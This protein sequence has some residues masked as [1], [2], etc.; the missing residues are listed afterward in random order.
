MRTVSACAE[1][2]DDVRPEYAA[3]TA[4]E[5]VLALNS[6]ASCADAGAPASDCNTL[7]AEQ[8]AWALS[9][10][11]NCAGAAVPPSDR[12]ALGGGDRD[13]AESTSPATIE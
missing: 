6:D 12:L 8:I 5:M 3:L 7:L 2:G 1:A 10:D 9:S 13:V 11:A 4:K